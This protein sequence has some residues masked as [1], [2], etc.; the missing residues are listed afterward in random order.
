LYG[1]ALHEASNPDNFT[2]MHFKASLKYIFLLMI[3][4]GAVHG[5]TKPA[6][7]EI[8]DSALAH[9]N[10]LTGFWIS[11]PT[12][13]SIEFRMVHH[14]LKLMADNSYSYHF[15]RTKDFPFNGTTISW[16]PHDCLVKKLDKDQIEI[17]YT[18]F[19]GEPIAVRYKRARPLL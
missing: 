12:H 1:K 6:P 14:E 19:G 3:I 10:F 8:Q 9:I 13:S 18:L 15:F 4:S 2:S 5:Q 16:P 7:F 11:D 17:Q